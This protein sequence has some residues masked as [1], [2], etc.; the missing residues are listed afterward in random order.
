MERLGATIAAVGVAVLIAA[1]VGIVLGIRLM[2]ERG[3]VGPAV[4]FGLIAGASAVVL[5]L[6]VFG[7][8]G[9]EPWASRCCSTSPPAAW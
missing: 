2:R 8:T 9:P 5:V 3:A 7:E 4:Y 6:D 1:V